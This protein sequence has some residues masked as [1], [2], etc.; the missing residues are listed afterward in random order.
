MVVM[1]SFRSVGNATAGESIGVGGMEADE[2]VGIGRDGKLFGGAMGRVNE[3]RFEFRDAD[4]V[5]RA[6]RVSSGDRA[7]PGTD[8][9]GIVAEVGSA[10]ACLPSREDLAVEVAVLTSAA[11]AR[12]PPREEE[13]MEEPRRR[14]CCSKAICRRGGTRE[15]L[16][17]E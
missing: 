2:G 13:G 3:R 1:N 12:M 14:H 5:E 11:A 15:V 8:G 10:S 7:S 16:W 4:E 9:G 6:E 17:N